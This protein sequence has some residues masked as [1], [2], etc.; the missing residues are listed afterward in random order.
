MLKSFWVNSACESQYDANQV[1][2]SVESGHA[3]CMVFQQQSQK[4]L[5]VPTPTLKTGHKEQVGAKATLAEVASLRW[6]ICS[7]LHCTVDQYAAELLS[8][9]Q[10]FLMAV[11]KDICFSC[12]KIKRFSSVSKSSKFSVILFKKKF[13]SFLIEIGK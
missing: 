7:R 3:R 8:N 5:F 12:R 4:F 9:D 11:V 1:R 10:E 2:D 6:N 13:S